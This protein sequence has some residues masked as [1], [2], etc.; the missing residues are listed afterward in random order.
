MEQ[1]AYLLC[2]GDVLDAY[3]GWPAPAAIVSDGAYGI[4]GFHGDTVGV[5]R[6]AEW[7]RPQ[8]STCSRKSG[9]A[10][11]HGLKKPPSRCFFIWEN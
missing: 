2:R 4:R 5:E 8:P 7:Y 10:P 3:D 6:L 11:E 1:P 9:R